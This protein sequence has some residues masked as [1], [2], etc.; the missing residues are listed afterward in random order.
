MNTCPCCSQ[1]LL[2]HSRQNQVY[3]FC[4]SCHQ[5]MPSVEEPEAD[6]KLYTA[7]NSVKDKL[8]LELAN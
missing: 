2:K 4:I 8:S 3:W 7:L 6:S 1:R 5:E